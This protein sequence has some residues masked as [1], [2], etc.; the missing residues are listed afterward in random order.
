MLIA[1]TKRSRFPGQTLQSKF[2]AIGTCRWPHIRLAQS[3]TLQSRHARQREI[4][5]MDVLETYE[6]SSDEGGAG[7]AAASACAPEKRSR[8]LKEDATDSSSNDVSLPGRKRIFAHEDGQW[9]AAVWIDCS[10]AETEL[11][12]WFHSSGQASAHLAAD[13]ASSASSCASG[14][15]AAWTPLWEDKTVTLPLHVSLC[16]PFAVRGHQI[17]AIVAALGRALA[18]PSFH[19][20]IGLPSATLV[21]RGG[22]RMFLALRV[23]GTAGNRIASLIEAVNGVVV[24]FGGEAYHKHPIPHVSVA[25]KA[26][27]ETKPAPEADEHEESAGAGG[28]VVASLPVTAVYVRCGDRTSV[29]R[30]ASA[31]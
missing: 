20:T 24:A 7:E 25:W 2:L 3:P 28:P 1:I 31:E 16:K 6:S 4:P 14:R 11:R 9:P 10:A 30:L 18:V 12:D 23:V 21:T 13:A 19:A 8:E 15:Q 27:T 5:V 17:P 26:A 22:D 29:I